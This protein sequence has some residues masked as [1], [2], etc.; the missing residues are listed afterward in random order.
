MTKKEAEQ[1]PVSSLAYL[2]DAVLELLV[3]ER[4]VTDGMGKIH[5]RANGFVTAVAQSAAAERLAAVFTEDEADVF[6]RGRNSTHTAP[7]SATHAQYSRATG[8]ECVFGYLH[9]AGDRNRIL[10]LFEEAYTTD[11]TG[12]NYAKE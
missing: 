1:M 5:E 2:G 7:K 10:Q 6:R 3:R 4:L 12:E 9:L 8:L 11:D